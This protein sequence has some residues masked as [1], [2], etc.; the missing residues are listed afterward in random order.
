[1]PLRLL[2]LSFLL[3][4]SACD[5]PGMGPD[6]RVAAR[7]ADGKAIGGACRYSMR[8]IEDCYTQNEDA[9]RAAIFAGWK[10]MDQY[11]RDNKVDG[12]APKL[13]AAVAKDQPVEEVVEDNKSKKGG[14]K[15]KTAA[16]GSDSKGVAVAVAKDA[17]TPAVSPAETAATKKP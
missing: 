12:V 6:P 15:A 4:L 9:S 13:A 14:A 2:A 7:E 16:K 11:M 3:L 10:D 17:A 5:I 1:M 8:S